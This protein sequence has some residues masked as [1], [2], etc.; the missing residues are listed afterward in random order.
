MTI[1]VAVIPVGRG[2][3][4]ILWWRWRHG[5]TLTSTETIRSYNWYWY[6]KWTTMML[7]PR[8]WWW[9][10]RFLGLG[11]RWG[12]DS[13]QVGRDRMD[14][15]VDFPGRG[16]CGWGLWIPTTGIR[17]HHSRRGGFDVVRM[18]DMWGGRR[19]WLGIAL[20]QC[21]HRTDTAYHSTCTGCVVTTGIT[22]D[23]LI[24]IGWGPVG[25][26]GSAWIHGVVGIAL[27]DGW[28]DWKCVFSWTDTLWWISGVVSSTGTNTRIII[29]NVNMV[30]MSTSS[31]STCCGCR[32]GWLVASTT[33]RYAAFLLCTACRKK[34]NGTET[35]NN[36]VPHDSAGV[37]AKIPTKWNHTTPIDIYRSKYGTYIRIWEWHTDQ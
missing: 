23:V 6:R 20:S 30:L 25:G 3:N 16:Q 33:T 28:M 11:G 12:T 5:R 8:R 4:R 21:R 1:V 32:C 24:F 13:G 7:P 2:G 17:V 15:G 37:R 14:C 35:R 19:G 34:C 36:A 18:M 27:S 9:P 22:A 31:V 29:G 10:G 26:G